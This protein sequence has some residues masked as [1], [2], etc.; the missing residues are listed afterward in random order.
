[1]VSKIEQ[2]FIDR[3]RAKKAYHTQ[4]AIQLLE[5]FYRNRSSQVSWIDELIN[6]EPDTMGLV[7]GEV[8]T[9]EFIQNLE[10]LK[11]LEGNL[12]D[13]DEKILREGSEKLKE[14]EICWWS[15]TCHYYRALFHKPKAV[16]FGNWIFYAMDICN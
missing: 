10:K 13:E 9:A 3:H 16:I 4:N 11:K 14:Y 8:T 1:M 12:T 2:L 6:I 5:F 15:S 7:Q